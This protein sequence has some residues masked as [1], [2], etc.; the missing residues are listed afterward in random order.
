[1]K[2]RSLYRVAD[3]TFA[4]T[5]DSALSK[6]LDLRA[7]EPFII[8]ES[9]DALFEV[10][11]VEHI[12]EGETEPIIVDAPLSSE[13]MVKVDVYGTPDGYIYKLTLPFNNLINAILKVDHSAHRCEVK[14]DGNYQSQTTALNN[15]LILSYLSFTLEHFTLL[16]HASTVIKDGRAYAFLGRSGTGKSTHSKMWLKSFE[17]SELLNDDHPII[18]IFEDGSTTIYG[19]PWSGKTPCYR[20]LSAPLAAIV[21]IEQYPENQIT[22]LSPFKAL[23]SITT[24]CSGVQWSPTLINHKMA[25]LDRAVRNIPCYLMKCLPNCEAAEVCHNEINK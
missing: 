6:E 11:V 21:R 24:S 10:E 19:S 8:D 7:Y 15:V 17:G 20:N 5:I 9:C 4:L 23:G 16:L 2:H 14:L 22:R 25:T 18:R 1:M 13:G 3:H 12:S